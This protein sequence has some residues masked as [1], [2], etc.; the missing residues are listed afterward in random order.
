MTLWDSMFEN[1]LGTFTSKYGYLAI[2]TG[3]VFLF[4]L[5]FLP[6]SPVW[7]F[8]KVI[9]FFAF[10][11]FVYINFHNILEKRP[12]EEGGDAFPEM[13]EE[14]QDWLQIQND[15]KVEET[16]EKFLDSTLQLVKRTL[17]SDT[18]VLLFANYSKKIFTIRHR[19]S[20]SGEHFINQNSFDILKGLPSLV[21]R[22]RTPLIENHLPEGN[23]ILPYYKNGENPA[24]SFAA[25]PIYFQDLIIGV[26]CADSAVEEAYSNEDLD[27][28]NQFS[29]LIT[30]QLIDSNKIYEFETENWVVNILFEIS[31]EMNHLR[32]PDELWNYLIQKIPQV[33]QCD[34]ISIAGKVDGEYGKIIRLE[35]GTGNLKKDKRFSLKDGIVGWVIRKNQSLL[36]EDFSTKENYV[37]R[38]SA[39]ESPAKQYFSLLSVPVA[40][41]SDVLGAICLESN[42]TKNFNDQQKRILQTIANQAATIFMTARTVSELKT[43]NFRDSQTQLANI[44]AF[45]FIMPKEIQRATQLK[46]NLHLLFFK[47]YF[48]LKENDARLFS[49]TINEFLSL[50]LPEISETDYIFHLF[51]DTFAIATALEGNEIKKRVERLLRK[52]QEKKLWSD[53]QAYDLYV[54]MGL[55]PHQFMTTEVDEVLSLGE[56]AI[57]QA[58]LKGPNNFSIYSENEEVATKF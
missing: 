7:I 23:E 44:N 50:A 24:K 31:Q 13:E 8:I 42:Q 45:K 21:L 30:Y 46:Q 35:G 55:L 48:Q 3:I 58:R 4:I 57:K 49:D 33:I 6:S 17:V 22:N 20:D 1:L 53:G 9:F 41:N 25:V 32:T 40:N 29:R 38:F 26:L 47:L 43:Y 56:A 18:I 28:L 5:G 19:V 51:A 12:P 15:Q 39:D 11:S 52:I 2:L 16:F 54:S 36:V 14:N 34:R 37:P 10:I 27:I